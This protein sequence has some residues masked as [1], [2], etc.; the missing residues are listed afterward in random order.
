MKGRTPSSARALGTSSDF[1]RSKADP[2]DTEL[3]EQHVFQRTSTS[4]REIAPREASL[5][6]EIRP[7]MPIRAE[8]ST[9]GVR[10]PDHLPLAAREFDGD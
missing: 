3:L 2:F 8:T 6:A 5:R 1:A 9:S 10:A 7:R 4:W